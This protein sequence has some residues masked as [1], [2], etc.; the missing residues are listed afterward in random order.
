MKLQVAICTL[1]ALGTAVAGPPWKGKTSDPSKWSH[2]DVE[3]ILS[4]SPWSQTANAEFPER[5]EDEPVNVYSLPGAQQAGLPGGSK[6]GATDGRWDGG[7]GRNTGHGQ[8]PTLPG[9]VRW[10]SA[11]PVREA[12]ALSHET[13]PGESGRDYILTVVGLVSAGKDQP[14][15]GLMG[16]STLRVPGKPPVGAEDMK[17]DS[18]TGAVHLYFPR[19]SAISANDKDV[20]FSTR[21]GSLTVVKKFHLAE[22]LYHGRLEL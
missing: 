14:L 21:F 4:N 19:S 5:Q 13:L 10:D 12:L 9:L 2:A 22:M 15:E 20:V 17:V 18:K 1:V 11:I 3:Q 7:V 8:V 16:H 6:A